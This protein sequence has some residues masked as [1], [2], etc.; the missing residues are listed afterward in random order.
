MPSR[1]TEH[2]STILPATLYGGEYL[3][4]HPS[5]FTPGNTGCTGG[6]VGPKA[7]LDVLE[8]SL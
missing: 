6:W 5:H 8:K 3:A 7:S 1:H 4:S 2:T